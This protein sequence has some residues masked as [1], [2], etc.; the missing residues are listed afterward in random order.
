MVWREIVQKHLKYDKPNLVNSIFREQLDNWNLPLYVFTTYMR[1]GKQYYSI[2][3]KVKET[4]EI[5][6]YAN[7]CIVRFREEDIFEFGKR[8]KKDVIKRVFIK[9]TSVFN[10]WKL[11]DKHIIK[12]CLEHDFRWWKV[13]KF[14][15]YKSE[16]D[17]R[18]IENLK[19]MITKYFE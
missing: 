15:K 3:H 14:M 4:G 19:L 5:K 10:K 13:K 16:K 2:K 12:R 8:L 11:D 6:W 17:M 7:D 9:E 18:D 1:T